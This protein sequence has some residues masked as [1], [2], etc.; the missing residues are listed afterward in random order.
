MLIHEMLFYACILI[1]FLLI[2]NT[3]VDTAQVNFVTSNSALHFSNRYA[4]SIN[5]V[6][7]NVTKQVA[8]SSDHNLIK[9][10]QYSMKNYIFIP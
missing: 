6:S 2:I 10:M 1:L 7:F 3:A 9:L 5:F 4:N 8:I